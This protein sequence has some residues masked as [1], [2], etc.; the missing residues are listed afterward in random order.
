MTKTERQF[1]HAWRLLL[2]EMLS[3]CICYSRLYW[4]WFEYVSPCYWIIWSS[5]VLARFRFLIDHLSGPCCSTCLFSIGT[6]V[7]LRLGHVSFLHWTMCHIFIGPLACFVFNHMSRC[8][9][10]M[11]CFF[12]FGHVAWQLPSTCRIFISPRVVPWLFLMLCTSS[13]TC[14]IFIWSRGL[15]RFYHMPNNQFITKVTQDRHCCI[16]WLHN[17]ST[18]S[19]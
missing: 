17:Y 5:L 18:M 8:C 4:R 10:S 2:L 13:F 7:V 11:F 15:P 19:T 14:R 9:P 3:T 16:D 6:R 12:L 1:R